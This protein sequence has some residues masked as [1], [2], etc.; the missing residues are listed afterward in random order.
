MRA[1]A[2]PS[3]AYYASDQRARR[4]LGQPQSTL[5]IRETIQN[6]GILLVATSQA[7]LGRN[8]A[9]LLGACIL[10]LVDAVIRSQGTLPADERR[11]CLVVV[12]E[13]QSIQG[14]LSEV[15]KFG[16]SLV[17]ATQ[18]LTKLDELSMTMRDT[19]LANIGCLGVFQ[20]SGHDAQRLRGEIGADRVEEHD[21]VSL[22]RHEC[23]MKLSS[24]SGGVSTLSMR[25]RPPSEGNS[26]SVA[27]IRERMSDYTELVGDV[28]K[29][30]ARRVYMSEQ[31][32]DAAG[33]ITIGNSPKGR[34]SGQGG[35]MASRE[36]SYASRR[37]TERDAERGGG[38]DGTTK[39]SHTNI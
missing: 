2:D 17:L 20:V 1:G 10:N 5:D 18:S 33:E 9:S 32:Y 13:M 27:G 26:A 38:E 8:V 37:R 23:Y 28:D 14:M 36:K 4:V 12:D 15:G 7:Y 3:R 34:A 30:L 31:P 29:L 16:G 11:G 22:P 6:G 19:I 25:V 39:N 21:I 24:L 35:N